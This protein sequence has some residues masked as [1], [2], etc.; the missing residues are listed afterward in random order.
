MNLRLMNLWSGIKRKEKKEMEKWY[1]LIG[2]KWIDYLNK[3][4]FK[5]ES[6]K[7][8]GSRE[9]IIEKVII[10]ANND[11][12]EYAYV[13]TIN[14]D[15]RSIKYFPAEIY[16]KG[17]PTQDLKKLDEILSRCR[18]FDDLKKDIENTL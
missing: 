13:I 1:H 16:A 15:D 10:E 6:G 17:S 14:F 3:H 9:S 18:T 8:V 7:I 5:W 12:T 4:G 2:S 11:D